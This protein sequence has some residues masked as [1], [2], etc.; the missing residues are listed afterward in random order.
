MRILIQ[1]RNGDSFDKVV[2]YA[3][4]ILENSQVASTQIAG[5][6][7]N[8]RPAILIDSSDL[9]EVLEILEKA[10]MRVSVMH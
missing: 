5:T 1:P 6:P 9:A 3:A 8:F 2:G 7:G 4:K 10:G